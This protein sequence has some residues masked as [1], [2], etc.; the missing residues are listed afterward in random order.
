[1]ATHRFYRPL[2]LTK[3]FA[4]MRPTTSTSLNMMRD[5]FSQIHKYY[6]FL[7]NHKNYNKFIPYFVK[8]LRLITK[9]TFY[10]HFTFYE[11]PTF[12]PLPYIMCMHFSHGQGIGWHVGGS[13]TNGASDSRVWIW[14]HCFFYKVC[15]LSATLYMPLYSARLIVRAVM[16]FSM[17]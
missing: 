9:N 16:D 2:F 12:P 3:Q 6:I 17:R 11:Y 13:W 10:Y 4:H 7:K 1:M 14:R 5:K 8:Q 15:R